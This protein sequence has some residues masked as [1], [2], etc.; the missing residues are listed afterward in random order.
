MAPELMSDRL[1][2]ELGQDEALESA[3]HEA[4]CGQLGEG[5]PVTEAG[6]GEG[7]NLWLSKCIIQN[8]Q[9]MVLMS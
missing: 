5:A 8:D 4:A 3:L 7:H 2:D 6:M 9:K 1:K